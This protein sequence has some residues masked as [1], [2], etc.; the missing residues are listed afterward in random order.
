MAVS[1]C[2]CAIVG[3]FRSAHKELVD[4]IDYKDSLLPRFTSHR[5][6]PTRLRPHQAICSAFFQVGIL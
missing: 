4:F 3:L 6:L 1:C 5:Q 2:D